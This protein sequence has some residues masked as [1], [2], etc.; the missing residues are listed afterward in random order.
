[1]SKPQKLMM[2]IWN[3]DFQPWNTGFNAALLPAV[4]KYDYVQ[5]WSYTAATGEFKELWK[6]NFQTWN[7]DRW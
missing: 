1:M 6:D 3:P 7:A 2:N 5:V 4:T